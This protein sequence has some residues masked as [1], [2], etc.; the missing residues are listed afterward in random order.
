[1][2]IGVTLPQFRDEGDSAVAAA[3]RAE[4]LGL[5][6]A[7]VFDHL[8]PIGRPDRPIVSALPLLGALAAETE[9]LLLGTLVARVGLVPDEV[10]VD[11]LSGLARLCP[12]RL[13]AGLGTG[14]HL[15]AQEN[16]AYG[17]GY[18]PAVE[19]RASLERCGSR[20]L[21]EGIPVWVGAGSQPHFLTREAAVRMGAALNVWQEKGRPV[22]APDP[23]LELTWAGP[24]RGDAADIDR[25][26]ARLAR[27][28][29]S[30]VVCA[31]PDSLESIAAARD[32][33]RR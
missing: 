4:K 16:L 19:R 29:A 27:A 18:P 8:W 25:S 2:K 33:L 17:V 31:W 14:D 30:W 7:F 21:Q 10:L 6:G 5:D 12:G 3:V 9:H 20:L 23:V 28:G 32:R 11:Q 22:L 15:S 13:I 24:L 1:M 26:L